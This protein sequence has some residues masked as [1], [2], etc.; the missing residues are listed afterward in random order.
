LEK[1]EVELTALVARESALRSALASARSRARGLGAAA[2]EQ[3][4]LLRGMKTAEDG[5]LLYLRKSEEARIGDA[6]D[7]RGI[8]NVTVAEP[9]IAPAL[10]RYSLFTT[11]LLGLVAACLGAVAAAFVAD[12]LDP[13]FRTPQELGECL[14][15]PVLASLPKE[16]A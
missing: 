15:M 14:R 3:Q 7:Q 9:P 5:Y 4:D 12:Y 10:P 2:I 16:I 6:L 1:A 11:L 13:A 8:V